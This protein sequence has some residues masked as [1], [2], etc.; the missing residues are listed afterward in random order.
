MD[1]PISDIVN[2]RKTRFGL[3]RWTFAALLAT[4]ASTLSI[5]QHAGASL[6]DGLRIKNVASAN[7]PSGDTDT[8]RLQ[9]RNARVPI[10]VDVDLAANGGA[11]AVTEDAINQVIAAIDA[12]PKRLITIRIKG[13]ALRF[14]DLSPKTRETLVNRRSTSVEQAYEAYMAAQISLLIDEV[15]QVRPGSPITIQGLPFE[16]RIADSAAVNGVFA[17][18]IERLSAIVVSGSV[19]VSRQSGEESVVL[20]RAFPIALKLAGNRAIFFAANGG[21]RMATPTSEPSEQKPAT[22]IERA[23]GPQEADSLPGTAT[24]DTL[25]LASDSID[26]MAPLSEESTLNDLGESAPD[27]VGSKSEVQVASSPG[28]SAPRSSGGLGAGGG[29]RSAPAQQSEASGAEDE[30]WTSENEAMNDVDSVSN[31]AAA[32]GSDLGSESEESP[33]GAGESDQSEA[34]S[35]QD[36][37]TAGSDSEPNQSSSSSTQGEEE[38]T[39]SDGGDTDPDSPASSSDDVHVPRLVAGGGAGLSYE[40]TQPIGEATDFGGQAIAIAKWDAVPYQDIDGVFNIGVIAFHVNGIGRVDFSLNGGPWASAQAPTINPRTSVSEYYAE[41][42]TTSLQDAEVLEVRA[43]VYPAVAG[44]PVALEPILFRKSAQPSI[45]YWCA[46]W[47]SDDTGDGS[48]ANPYRQP[49]EALR[50]HQI[51]SGGSAAVG[52]CDGVT[53]LLQ[54]GEYLFSAGSLPYPSTEHG[55]ATIS[56][57]PGAEASQVILSD[58]F[59]IR[60]KRI[61]AENL[62]FRNYSIRS[63]T[64]PGGGLQ[65]LWLNRVSFRGEGPASGRTPYHAGNFA[66]VYVCDSEFVDLS[67][68]PKGARLVRGTTVHNIG[69]DAFTMSECVVNCEASKIRPAPGAHPDVFQLFCASDDDP[70]DKSMIVYGLS[71]LD[72]DAQGIFLADCSRYENI[73]LVNILISKPVASSASDPALSQVGGSLLRNCIFE[74]ITMPNQTLMFR[75]E[76]AEDVLVRNSV[77]W[78]VAGEQSF[79]AELSAYDNHFIDTVTYGSRFF[80]QRSS[81]GEVQFARFS[82]GL[83]DMGLVPAYEAAQDFAPGGEG[84]LRNR[85]SD[86]FSPVDLFGAARGVPSDIGA[87]ESN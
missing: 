52:A 75:C 53:I 9:I 14:N 73:A 86:S 65:D 21:W 31:A 36:Q 29:G 10:F 35:S 30:P 17:R 47:G 70:W 76:N 87:I 27:D 7:S 50:R 25:A 33:I 28:V 54:E 40:P 68:G 72:I 16:G 59:G 23:T 74:N 45:Q 44:I 63:S 5:Q 57:A 3:L 43:I 39:S 18:I 83:G 64:L 51:I 81:Q 34:S 79:L 49:G 58:G 2:I 60:T 77:F 80:G 38:D 41:I 46:P 82:M 62:T 37:S 19:M 78:R 8:P 20:H 56:A 1:T 26:D 61:K 24:N 11:P 4:C 6:Q 15:D 69:A 55:W 48:Q 85:C 84:L 71:A 12:N 66:S 32:A 13:V 67:D 22:R 42:E